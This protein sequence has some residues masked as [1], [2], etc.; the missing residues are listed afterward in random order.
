MPSAFGF[1]D[2][3]WPYNPEMA[4]ELLENAG[5][6]LADDDFRYQGDQKIGALGAGSRPYTG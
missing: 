3:D 2:S 1:Q 6:S 4:Q 5:W